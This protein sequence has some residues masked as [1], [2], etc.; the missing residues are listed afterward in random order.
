M[1]ILTARFP[2]RQSAEVTCL[3]LAEVVGWLEQWLPLAIKV[4]C[5]EIPAGE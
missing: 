1:Y 2:Y 5:R 4:E 3:T